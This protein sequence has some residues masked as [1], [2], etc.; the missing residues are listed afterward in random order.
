MA[1]WIV[2]GYNPTSDGYTV[3]PTVNNM[4]A[5]AQAN[6]ASFVLAAGTFVALKCVTQGDTQD[7][8]IVL[9]YQPP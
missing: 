5:D 1:I 8:L 3:T 6:Y 4:V 2:L 7:L 9:T